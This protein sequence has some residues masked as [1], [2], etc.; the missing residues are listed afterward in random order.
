VAASGLISQAGLSD[1]ATYHYPIGSSDNLVRTSR[2]SRK[3]T[4]L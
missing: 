1:R 4:G 2:K 3:G